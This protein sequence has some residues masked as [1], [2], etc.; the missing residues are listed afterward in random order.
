MAVD[1]RGKRVIFRLSCAAKRASEGDV[2]DVKGDDLDVF[3]LRDSF[4]SVALCVN[5]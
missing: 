5:F 1:R 3:S 2:S 4:A